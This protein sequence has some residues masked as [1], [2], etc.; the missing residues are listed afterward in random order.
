MVGSDGKGGEKSQVSKES[1][2]RETDKSLAKLSGKERSNPHHVSSSYQRWW[3]EHVEQWRDTGNFGVPQAGWELWVNSRCGTKK[4]IYALGFGLWPLAI[5]FWPVF[6]CITH[7]DELFGGACALLS[8][9]MTWP[10]RAQNGAFV[11]FGLLEDKRAHPRHW[12][13]F[14][15]CWRASWSWA[16]SF[17]STKSNLSPKSTIG[18]FPSRSTAV[19]V[20]SKSLEGIPLEA[21]KTTIRTLPIGP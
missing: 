10:N 1:Q 13:F 20:S 8:A 14:V 18:T 2:Q 5:S 6:H 16:L 4:E 12:S 19:I 17:S 9:K 21:S 15:S 3:I 7:F 11:S